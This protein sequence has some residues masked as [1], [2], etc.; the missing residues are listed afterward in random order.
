M[1]GNDP[2][3]QRRILGRFLPVAMILAAVI[4]DLLTPPAVGVMPILTTAA[5]GFAALHSWRVTLIYGLAAILTAFLLFEF[6]GPGLNLITTIDLISCAILALTVASVRHVMVSQQRSL[7]VAQNF[8]E[9]LVCSVQPAPPT[10][11]GELQIAARY[12]AA[13]SETPLGGDFYSIVNTP[14]GVRF[15]IGDVRG[16]GIEAATE[17]VH[18]LGSFRAVAEEGEITE[19]IDRTERAFKSN[20]IHNEGE[21]DALECFATA[22]FG[23]IDTRNWHIRM[24]HRGHISPLLIIGGRVHAVEAQEP[25][26]PLGLGD[27]QLGEPEV[28]NSAFPSGSTFVALTDGVTEARD[29]CGVFYDPIEHLKNEL[30][31]GPEDLLDDL[32][33]DISKNHK[34]EDDIAV[35]A[36]HR[37]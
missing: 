18:L 19:V 33:K 5:V 34:I 36:M 30:S 28:W 17:V 26:L 6:H 21:G 1:A 15:T 32:L 4:V 35:I 37:P 31:S 9:S 22:I 25:G 27:F 16:K 10:C 12:I 29:S 11:V 8:A 20:R 23:E 13:T 3:M 2:A 14:F 24:V 7:Q